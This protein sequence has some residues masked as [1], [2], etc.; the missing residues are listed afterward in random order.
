MWQFNETVLG[1][2]METDNWYITTDGKV[3]G[4]RTRA[5]VGG[6]LWRAAAV[7]GASPRA[8]THSLTLP[9]THT[10]TPVGE[11]T[12]LTPFGKY[13]GNATTVTTKF[14]PGPQPDSLFQVPNKASCTES[15]KCGNNAA[16]RLAGA[17]GI[18]RF[19]REFNYMRACARRARARAR[20]VPCSRGC[21]P[22]SAHAGDAR[23][24]GA[25]A[26]SRRCERPPLPPSSLAPCPPT[27]IAHATWHAL[28]GACSADAA[29]NG[30]TPAAV[31]RRAPAAT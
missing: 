21:E 28:P 20:P 26:V 25:A 2:T 12:E 7:G 4:I 16:L 30:P 1:M 10:Q 5:G 8:Q 11:Y 17:L 29:M 13:A 22:R 18:R 15:S 19:T 24:A 3:R 27:P 31:P 23:R 14:Q 9:H 6:A